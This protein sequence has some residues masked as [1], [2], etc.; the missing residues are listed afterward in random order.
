MTLEVMKYIFAVLCVTQ[1]WALLHV[2][3]KR[4]LLHLH[5]TLH[6]NHAACV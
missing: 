2:V 4:Q 6:V 3:I 1:R 5:N